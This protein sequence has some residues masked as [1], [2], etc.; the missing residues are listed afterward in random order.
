MKKIILGLALLLLFSTHIFAKKVAFLIGVGNI[1]NNLLKTHEDI[2]TMKVL[3]GNTYD[4]VIVLEDD[5]ATY[6]NVKKELELLYGLNSDDTLFFYYTGH[7]CRAYGGIDEADGKD[8]F[9]MLSGF[10]YSSYDPV[11]VKKGIMLDDELNYHFSK[12]AAK[13]VII[14]DSCHSQTAM[15]GYTEKSNKITSIPHVKSMET[16][17]TLTQER[18]L[19]HINAVNSNYIQLSA[20]LDS[21]RADDSKKGGIFT[22]T[23]KE[24]LTNSKSMSFSTLMK[25]VSKRLPY[26][27][28][29]NSRPGD[30][31]PNIDDRDLSSDSFQTKSIFVVLQPQST[32]PIGGN[33]SSIKKESLEAFL[34]S[35]LGGLI[36][37]KQEKN[38]SKFSF[39]DTVYLKSTHTSDYNHLYMLEVKNNKYTEVTSRKLSDCSSKS[40]S[41][42]NLSATAPIG[43]TNIYLIA[44]KYPLSISKKDFV[45]SLKSQLKHQSFE[46]GMVSFETV[47]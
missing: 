29:K 38:K 12:I 7:G 8:E 1:P 45:E 23:L 26:V 24:V 40:C 47:E 13:K 27:A 15:K 11:T 31:T 4:D 19:T 17:F 28:Q 36:F 5:R 9:L 43:D 39:Y 25:K 42:M 35:K 6:V 2:E 20:S 41:F 37:E 34:Q 10:E 44:S 30:F 32:K 21:E 22:L 33:Q 18:N 14:F 16:I 3:I 46:V